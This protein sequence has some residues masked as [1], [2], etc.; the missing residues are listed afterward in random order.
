MSC[1]G[2]GNRCVFEMVTTRA[3]SRRSQRGGS[4]TSLSSRSNG[5][6]QTL[7]RV[8][9]EA[10]L[11]IEAALFLPS[12]AP[13]FSSSAPESNI[14]E[15]VPNAP[16]FGPDPGPMSSETIPRPR[17]LGG[18]PRLKV[19]MAK[20]LARIDGVSTPSAGIFKARPPPLTTSA[21]M[22]ILHKVDHDLRRM[23]QG[24]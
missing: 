16:V 8:E 19:A 12:P 23:E 10:E 17:S 15:E 13:S 9:L 20:F 22:A 11:R 3:M 1:V 6:D 2:L 24:Q 5:R 21:V 18:D 7:A 14:P 4:V